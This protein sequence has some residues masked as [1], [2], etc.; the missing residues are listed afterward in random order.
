[1]KIS[2]SLSTSFWSKI[3]SSKK[4]SPCHLDYWRF[5]SRLPY[6]KIPTQ[7]TIMIPVTL[8]TKTQEAKT[9]SQVH[10]LSFLTQGK[11]Q[12]SRPPLPHITMGLTL[13]PSTNSRYLDNNKIMSPNWHSHKNTDADS[14][15]PPH[16]NSMNKSKTNPLR[17]S[18]FSIQNLKDCRQLC[19]Q[20]HS[21]LSKRDPPSNQKLKSVEN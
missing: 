3:V 10:L 12:Y 1:M 9:W 19:P 6:L 11:S 4:V 18:C 8:L 15:K 7:K 17:V 14:K 13:T 2:H 20:D 5:K 21:L 16:T